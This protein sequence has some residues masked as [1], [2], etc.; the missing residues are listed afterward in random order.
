MAEIQGNL[1][2]I[3]ISTDGGTTQKTLIC[4]ED[5]SVGQ[6]SSTNK[7]TTRCGV[8]VGIS[9]NEAV[10][11]G[12]FV[13]DDAPTAAQ[14]S[15]IDMQGWKKNNTS[16]HIEV[17]HSTTPSKYFVA[18]TGYLTEMTD[19]LPSD[20]VVSSSFTFEVVGTVELTA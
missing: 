6:T 11:S 13:W 1:I 12:T 3:K 14:V 17:A 9:P 15:G 19:D 10:I 16:L 7:R 18:G 20:D 8:K 5:A 2:L 4:L